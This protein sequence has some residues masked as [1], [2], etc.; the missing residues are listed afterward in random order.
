M[1]RPPKFPTSRHQREMSILKEV[2]KKRP[3][4]G[5]DD[6][7]GQDGND[8]LFQSMH[9][10]TAVITQLFSYMIRIGVQYGYICT[11]EAFVFMKI[12]D[13]PSTVYYYLSI[14]NEDMEQVNDRHRTA[15]AQVLAFT[16]QSLAATPPDQSWHDAVDK[17]DIWN[18]EY[19]DVL[20][21][22]PP[23]DRK[24]R[25]QTPYKPGGWKKAVRSRVKTRSQCQPWPIR[26]V[27]RMTCHPP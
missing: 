18:V 5:K 10:I 26:W 6:V 7:I 12:A 9:L 24:D 1:R 20:R 25:P 11:G 17:L 15:V 19:E 16:L 13:D 21:N 2:V 27:V 4:A 3:L 23:T 14:P 22:I 8:Y